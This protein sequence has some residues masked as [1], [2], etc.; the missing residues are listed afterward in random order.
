M[1]RYV[2]VSSK[3]ENI[4]GYKQIIDKEMMRHDICY[5]YCIFNNNDKSF[6]SYCSLKNASSVFIITALVPSIYISVFLCI[7]LGCLMA[8]YMHYIVVKDEVKCQKD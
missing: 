2:I 5:R 8:A 6:K 7:L 4:K 1:I 3:E